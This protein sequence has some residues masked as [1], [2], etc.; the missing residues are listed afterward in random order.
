MRAASYGYRGGVRIDMLSREYPPEIYG[1]AGVHVAELVRALRALPDLSINVSC[2]GAD[3]AEPG[4]R[5]YG[6]G[7]PG[8]NPALAALG[9]GLPMAQDAAGAQLVHSHT[10]Y[11]ALAG[12]LASLLHGI[13]HVVTAH[14]L[15]PLR[16]WK[17]EQLGG[18]YAI[19]SWAEQQ[20][21]TTAAAVIA[22]SA[23]MRRDVLA[24]YPML[25]PDK[26][27]VVHNGVD[28]HRWSP[29]SDPDRVRALGVDPDQPAVIFVGRITRQKGLGYLLEAATGLPPQV[30][31]VLCAGSADTP[32]LAAEIR[33]AVDDARR[34]RAVIWHE[35]MLPRA[36]LRALLSAATVFA[37]P[38]I[39]EPL[40]IV[41]L[42]AMAC[43]LPVVATA[44]GGIP[45][46]VRS[47]QTGLLVPIEP[48]TDGT[49]A[50]ADPKKFGRELGAALNR[51]LADPTQ[52]RAWGLAGRQRV[53]DHFDWG[54]I[55]HRTL[56]IYRSITTPTTPRGIH[57]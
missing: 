56:L 54:T 47:E 3:R 30:Q 18:G 36:D 49:G 31:L 50:P 25:D 52:A 6:V 53:L 14:S 2:F 20:A 8:M 21:I 1:G 45:E 35:S 46:V 29:H 37:C 55:A 7:S 9:V 5:G 42:E 23:Q 15:E 16:P 11:T 24:S 43:E 39:Y 32:E 19:S 13:P 48:G 38:S 4:S 41:N 17:A 28:P 26:V 33:A 51:T 44:T 22:V 40:G 12:Q 34:Y 27:H 57:D 10:W